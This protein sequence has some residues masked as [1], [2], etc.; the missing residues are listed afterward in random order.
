MGESFVRPF[1]IIRIIGKNAVE[2]RLTEAFS[3]KNPVFPVRL[4]KKY[5]K[6]N[7][8][9]FTN[10]K[11]IVTHERLVEEYDS[12]VP[13]KKIMKARKIRINGKKIDN[14]WFH[15]RI[16][17]KIYIDGYPKKTSQMDI[18]MLEDLDPLGLQKSL[19]NDEPHFVGGYLSL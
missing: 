12:P 14:T 19:I 8:E 13:V 7:H 18:F 5:H 16:N 2:V 11:Q 4:V 9:A 3:R 6:T 10:R 17:Q 1:T 15:L